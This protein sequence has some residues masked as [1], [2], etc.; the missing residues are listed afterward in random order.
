MSEGERIRTKRARRITAALLAAFL[1]LAGLAFMGLKKQTDRIFRRK[2]PGS[3][4][5]Y[6]PSGKFLRFAAFGYS[7]LAADFVYLWA[8]QYYS[9]PTIDDRFDHLAHVFSITSE[10][11]PHYVD[12][13]DIGAI[14]A[15]QEAGDTETAF[16]IL[17]MGAEKNPDE[18]LFP[19]SAGH[20]A[21][22]TLKDFALAEKYFETC[23]RIPGAPD[24]VPRL[25]ANAIFRKG[26]LE[27]AWETWLDIYNSAPDERTRRIASNHLYNVKA[28]I[29][30][31][32]ISEALTA[33]RERRGRSPETLEELVR[34]GF[35]EELP[36]DLDGRDYVYDP[37]TGL[38]KT[39][40]IPW[41][42]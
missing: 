21:M 27:T 16:R 41:R 22:M 37:K 20:I 23:M 7:A 19:F 8:I 3:S 25:R 24:F 29:D 35:L 18:W 2:V 40:V 28:A 11:D 38:V 4:I 33:F 13:Y 17:D 15:V 42:R 10:L 5:I 12:P 6:I 9:T 34:G 26:D 1:V 39:A 14:I 36:K 30:T 32:R 31:G